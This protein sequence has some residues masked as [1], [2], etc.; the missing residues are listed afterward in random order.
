ML[1]LKNKPPGNKICSTQNNT[2]NFETP[3][4]TGSFKR[5]A[6]MWVK[7]VRK[8][9]KTSEVCLKDANKKEGVL[10][11]IKD[12]GIGFDTTVKSKGVGLLHIKARA[13]LFNEEMKLISFPGKGCELI[14]ILLSNYFLN[15]CLFYPIILIENLNA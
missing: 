7:I 14:V 1:K 5:I 11:N 13:A 10:L 8:F 2:Q 6:A 3:L 15:K 12:N 4:F 9:P